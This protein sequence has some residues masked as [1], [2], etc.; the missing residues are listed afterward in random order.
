MV[1]TREDARQAVMCIMGST[2][3]S[4]RH[5]ARQSGVSP[6]TLCRLLTKGDGKTPYPKTLKLIARLARKI[7]T[8]R[9]KKNEAKEDT[10]NGGSKG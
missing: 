10:R 7:E 5:V 3:W 8:K 1:E 2:G 9:R 4:L 6:A